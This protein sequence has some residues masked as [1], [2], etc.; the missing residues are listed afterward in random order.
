MSTSSIAIIGAGFS[1]TLLAINLLQQCPPT[2]RIRLIERASHFGPGQAYGIE[3]PD[4]LL[5]VPAGRMSA[6]PDQPTHFLDW[7]CAQPASETGVPTPDAATFAPRSVYGRYLRHLVATTQKDEQARRFEL[8]SGEVVSVAQERD[9]FRLRLDQGRILEDSMVVIATGNNPLA[10]VPSLTPEVDQGGYYRHDPWAP[11]AL[12]NLRP[13]DPILLIGTGLTTVDCALRL[14]RDGHSGPIHLLSRR[15]LLPCSHDGGAA[16]LVAGPN[17]M[18]RH[19]RALTRFM[20]EESARVLA[21][22]GTWRAVVDA[23]RPITQDLWQGWS[24]AERRMFLTHV[25]PWWDIHRHRMAPSVAKRIEAGR[26]SGQIQVHAGRVMGITADGSQAEVTWQPRGTSG[27]STLRVARVINC[28]GPASDI[29]RSPD[30]LC[31]S[32]LQSGMAR[33]DQM[34]LGLDVTAAG[35]LISAD[36]CVSQ[37]MFGVGPICR[38]ALWEITAV[39]DIRQQCAALGRHIAA[40]LRQDGAGSESVVELRSN[41]TMRYASAENTPA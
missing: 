29:A 28:T 12:T 36:G 21:A 4:L 1:G 37:R 19:L 26:S 18:P 5:N 41:P 8:I 31:Q 9:C 13:E 27:R 7:L 34:R 24:S 10:P 22:G 11:D 6:F 15:G 17:E 14:L 30:I 33:P 38:G 25:R 39:P 20:R 32:L 2:T 23:I 35:A 16:V 40:V 3:D